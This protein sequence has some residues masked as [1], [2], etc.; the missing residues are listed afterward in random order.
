[1]T[2]SKERLFH[3]RHQ[4]SSHAAEGHHSAQRPRPANDGW[5][6]GRCERTLER[7]F[8]MHRQLRETDRPMAPSPVSR[9]QNRLGETGVGR[10]AGLDSENAHRGVTMGKGAANSCSARGDAV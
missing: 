3:G 7:L 8:I 5:G 2:C 4:V 1:M 10:I 6:G 9:C